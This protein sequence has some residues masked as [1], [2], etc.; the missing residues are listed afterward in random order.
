M[1]YQTAREVDGQ[2]MEVFGMLAGVGLAVR[3]I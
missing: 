1:E 3:K 2:Q